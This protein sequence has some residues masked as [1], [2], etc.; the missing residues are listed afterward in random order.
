MPYGINNNIFHKLQE[1]NSL[2][3]SNWTLQIKS[4]MKYAHAKHFQKMV[5]CNSYLGPLITSPPPQ[6]TVFTLYVIHALSTGTYNYKFY[7]YY[8]SLYKIQVLSRHVQSHY[9]YFSKMFFFCFFFYKTSLIL[10]LCYAHFWKFSLFIPDYLILCLSQARTFISKA[11][12]K[13]LLK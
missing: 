3:F 13:L 9:L 5:R 11:I 1:K 6:I 10:Y 2:A 12:L 7:A 8:W 4:L